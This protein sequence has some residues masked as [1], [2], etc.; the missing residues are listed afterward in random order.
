MSEHYR[1]VVIGGGVVGSSVLYHL[2]KF[3]WSDVCLLERSVLTAGS[4]WH[5]AGGIHALNADP[6]MAALQAYT[7]DLLSQIQ[8][9]S[10]QDIGLNMT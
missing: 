6:N 2:A 3:G 4:S 1:A 8:S 10:G 5:A 9:E 7:I